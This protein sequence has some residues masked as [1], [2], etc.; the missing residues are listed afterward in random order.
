[1]ANVS[2]RRSR[3]MSPFDG[4]S[5]LTALATAVAIRLGREVAALA[6]DVAIRRRLGADDARDGRRDSTAELS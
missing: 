3:R 2:E 6:R 1:M 4:E 5:E